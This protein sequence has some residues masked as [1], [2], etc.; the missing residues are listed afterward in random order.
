MFL[1]QIQYSS[2][3][4]LRS[5]IAFVMIFSIMCSA[6]LDVNATD[7]T[8]YTFGSNK[9][10]SDWIYG[11]SVYVTSTG[12]YYHDSTQGIT[13][14]EIDSENLVWDM[15]LSINLPAYG[16]TGSYYLEF[17]EKINSVIWNMTSSI[18]YGLTAHPEVS[19][20]ETQQ[21]SNIGVKNV[22]L[23]VNGNRID[24]PF[25]SGMSTGATVAPLDISSFVSFD[26]NHLKQ[27][28]Q[29]DVALHVVFNMSASVDDT[30]FS[31]YRYTPWMRWNIGTTS[32]T[33]TFYG[34]EYS[35]G[36]SGAD[37]SN[38][39]DILEGALNEQTEVQKEQAETSKG[40][41]SSITD[42]FGSFFDN[43]I[44]SVISVFVPS[45]EE[46]SGLFD[47]LNQFF[48][49]TFGFLYY[50]F[51]FIIKA[52]DIFLNSDSSTGLT[53]PSFSIMGYEVWG[54]QTYDLASDE[55]A[56]T[57]FTYVR[58]GTG[59]LLSMAFVAYLRNFFDKRFGGGGS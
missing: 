17:D 22:Y 25:S 13:F 8:L 33:F 36:L 12:E 37:I 4:V 18:E 53:F 59:T 47:E 31:R 26:L 51:E 32:N 46:M 38:Q 57:V 9:Y 28:S 35:L 41:L 48:S 3:L 11:P 16:A 44:N 27:I 43:L 40:I 21:H 14:S 55:L 39:T 56:G 2:R 5:C 54:K 34:F 19:S 15:D 24:L 49:D 20:Y 30:I 42:F 29:W 50:P 58:I 52:F 45:S 1:K 6:T 7:Y 23:V 10:T